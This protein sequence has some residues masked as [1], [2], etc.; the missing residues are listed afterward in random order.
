MRNFLTAY[1]VLYT[2]GK[3]SGYPDSKIESG[4]HFYFLGGAGEVGNVGCIIEDKTGTRL[5]I[6]YGMAPTRPPKYPS[7]SPPV[8]DAIITHSHI[9]HIGMAPW[10][11]GAHGTT[12]HGTALTAK[13]SEIM[14]RDTYKVSS[15]EGY[16]LAWDKRDLDLALEAWTTHD[17]GEWFQIGQWKCK[18]HLAGHMP[19]A[20]M[21]EIVTPT[22][23]ILWTGDVDTRDSPNV[24]GAKP[25]PCDILC[26]EG[27]YGGRNH[28]NRA[29]EE[30]RFVDRVLEVV[31]RGGIALVPAFASGRG[32]DVLRILHDEA[33]HLNV[34]FDGMGTRLTKDWLKFP[35]YIKNPKELVKTWKWVR[36]VYGKS[37]R[38]KALNANVIVTTS[39]MLDGGP[40]LW[41]LN[42]LRQN[43]NNAIL[44]TG[45]QADGSGGRQLLD[46]G[47][48]A[49]YGNLT[50]IDLE[51][52]QFA[53]SNHADGPSLVKFAQLCSPKEI[54]LFHAPEE[55]IISLKNKLKDE[56]NI[57]LPE[58]NKSLFLRS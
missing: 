57:Y 52:D 14:W 9:D 25:I 45:Y 33:S 35:E 7:E 30:K 32:Q 43:K 26:L 31:G 38:K 16:P 50:K 27:T 48:I 53:L 44:L 29:E 1:M 18:F 5:L 24:L 11:V 42:R 15:I 22:T 6:D 19:G 49:I 23:T 13:V 47:K 39:G 40:A 10:L 51:I 56:F 58:N 17:I 28:P 37:D 41:Y 3:T 8:L 4:I 55:G 46:E 54:I 34:H 2:P 36:R 20:I 21:V 12:L